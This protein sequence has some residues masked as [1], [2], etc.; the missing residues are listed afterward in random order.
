MGRCPAV[1]RNYA[2]DVVGGD[3][4]VAQVFGGSG[5]GGTDSKA[6]FESAIELSRVEAEERSKA[7]GESLGEEDEDAEG[8]ENEEKDD[9]KDEES[10]SGKTEGDN[11]PNTPEP[12]DKPESAPEPS[13]K[14]E[15]APEPSNKPEPVPESN[16]KQEAVAKSNEKQESVPDD[17]GA[18]SAPPGQRPKLRSKMQSRRDHQVI[19][20]RFSPDFA[21]SVDARADTGNKKGGDLEKAKV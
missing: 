8:N 10:V 15:S 2:G 9:S 7:E 19:V 21:V 3:E 1:E 16:E 18:S 20:Q 12:S 17:S 5:S 14:P 4:K 11:T 13:D 6:A